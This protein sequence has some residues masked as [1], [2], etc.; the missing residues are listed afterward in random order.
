MRQRHEQQ[1]KIIG[2]Y[3]RFVD[4]L[5]M[6]TELINDRVAAPE[7]HNHTLPADGLFHHAVEFP[8]IFL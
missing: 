1:R 2:V 7:G 3:P 8:K 6:L 5:I 4:R